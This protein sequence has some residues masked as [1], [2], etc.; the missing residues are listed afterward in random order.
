MNLSNC[1]K[2]ELL[3]RYFISNLTYICCLSCVFCTCQPSCDWHDFSLPLLCKWYR[4]CSGILYSVEWQLV[5][6][7]WDILLVPTSRVRKSK[8]MPVTLQYAATKGMVWV[9]TSYRSALCEMPEEWRS[10]LAIL[11][12]ISDIFVNCNL[13]DTQWQYYST[14]LHT[15][16]T[17]NNSMKQNI[18]NK[19]YII[20]RI[21]KHNNKNI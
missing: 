21:Y 8:K 10:H 2:W 5:T 19:T 12:L 15:N 7:F 13:V 4:C 11:H 14:H 1:S 18:Q 20:I 16:S 3:F 17:Q 6:D 9:V